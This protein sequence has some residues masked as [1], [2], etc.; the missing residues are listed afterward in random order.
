MTDSLIVQTRTPSEL[1]IWWTT[2]D[3]CQA[4]GHRLPRSVPLYIRNQYHLRQNK[5]TNGVIYTD[6][7]LGRIEIRPSD[8]GNLARTFKR[9]AGI[10]LRRGD[11]TYLIAMPGMLTTLNLEHIKAIVI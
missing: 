9:R 6:I 2:F 7:E 10:A 8:V 11:A 1:L 4:I 3:E 5:N